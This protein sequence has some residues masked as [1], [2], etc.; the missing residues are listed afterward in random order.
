MRRINADGLEL[1]KAFEG[2]RL[3]AYRDP[4]GIWTVGYGSTGAHVKRGVTLTQAQADQLLRLD[5]DRFEATVNAATRQVPTTDNQFA[6]MVSMAF[7]CGEGAFLKSSI[8]RFHV[9][10]KPKLAAA[11]FLL[12]I[13][14]GKRPLK[15]LI[16]RRHAER[17]LYLRPDSLTEARTA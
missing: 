10:G 4:V 5:L 13:K 11:A 17:L 15:G 6:A 2:C 7:N 9:A 8:R 3:T 14:A 12:W 16:R 1:I